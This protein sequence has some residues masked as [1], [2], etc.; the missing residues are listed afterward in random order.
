MKGNHMKRLVSIWAPVLAWC[1]VIFY[2]S[3]IPDLGTGLGQWDLVLRK[4]AHITE[5]AILAALFWRALAKGSPLRK[6]MVFWLTVGFCVLYAVS[7]EWHQGFVPGRSPAIL[8]VLID[9]GGTLLACL[10]LRRKKPGPLAFL[11]SN[12]VVETQ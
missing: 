1:G 7:D 10:L 11:F 3:G 6:P 4:M 5:Y 2:L 9:S 12:T 8:D